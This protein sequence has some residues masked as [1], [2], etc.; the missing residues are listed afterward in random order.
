MCRLERKELV[1]LS[2]PG[3]RLS[4]AAQERA[5]ILF[6]NGEDI[7]YGYAFTSCFNFSSSVRDW[8][9]KHL[10]LQSKRS[11]GLIANASIE[12]ASLFSLWKKEKIRKP[13]PEFSIA[14]HI[15]HTNAKDSGGEDRGEE[16]CLR[17]V[18]EAYMPEGAVCVV[19]LASDRVATLSRMAK[20]IGILLSLS[21]FPSFLVTTCPFLAL[22][23]LEMPHNSM[24]CYSDEHGCDVRMSRKESHKRLRRTHTSEHGPWGDGFTSIADIELLSRADHFIGSAGASTDIRTTTLR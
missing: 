8:N 9:D 21:L 6:S 16:E 23:Y 2:K 19:Y 14:L 15:R 3:S 4:A 22:L 7:A 18:I 12:K 5:R 10:Y 17:T 13:L 1:A 20:Y 11:Q 24:V